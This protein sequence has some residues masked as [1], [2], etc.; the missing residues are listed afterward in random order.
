MRLF[1]DTS[2]YV[3]VVSPRD[4]SHADAT[5]IV[6]QF[7]GRIVTTEYVMVEV[8]NWLA[9]SGNR[10]LFIRLNQEVH[11]DPKTLVIPA[12]R[13]LYD[14]GVNLYASRQ[15]KDWSLTDCI[16]FAAMHQFGLTNAL[17]ADH[18][19]QQAGFTAMLL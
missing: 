12:D 6:R 10:N 14:A 4:A 2:F 19:F 18:H 7:K 13:T 1:A 16:S 5:D 8:G 17:T 11:A 9:S 3:A 15:D